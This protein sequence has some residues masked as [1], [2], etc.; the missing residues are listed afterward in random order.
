MLWWNKFKKL[1]LKF[2]RVPV[3]QRYFW[4][5]KKMYGTV[6]A[7][8]G[9]FQST[10]T[11]D[12]TKSPQDP[13]PSKF[14]KFCTFFTDWKNTNNREICLK[15]RSS[16]PT[17]EIYSVTGKLWFA[18]GSVFGRQIELAHSFFTPCL[19]RHHDHIWGRSLSVFN[20]TRHGINIKENF[21]RWDGASRERENRSKGR[22][23]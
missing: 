2:K 10:S 17:R 5:K 8:S 11:S 21:N 15:P 18:M 19:N 20:I 14:E 13:R 4:P 12:R 3:C 22:G 1:V 16:H 9:S 23:G 6:F 7:A